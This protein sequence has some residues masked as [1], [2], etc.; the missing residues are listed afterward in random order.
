VPDEVL[1]FRLGEEPARGAEERAHVST[2]RGR[3]ARR[4][5]FSSAKACSIGLKSGQKRHGVS[6]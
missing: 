6:M 4:N 3:A 5:A 1:A 2:L